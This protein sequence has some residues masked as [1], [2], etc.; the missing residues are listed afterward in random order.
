MS[1][2]AILFMFWMILVDEVAQQDLRIH[3]NASMEVLTE[4][5]ALNLTCETPPGETFRQQWLHPLQ[6]ASLY[7]SFLF[8]LLQC[9]Q[10]KL[11]SELKTYWYCIKWCKHI[12]CVSISNTA[13]YYSISIQARDAVFMKLVFPDKVLYILNI[14]KASVADSGLYQC[15]VTNQLTGQTKSVKLDVTVHG[16]C[17][18]ASAFT[19]LV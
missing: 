17:L 2:I 11:I 6:Q 16:M 12:P 18:T 4:G 15:A 3:L 5:D 9:K 10:H 14:P 7:S 13:F 1:L 8:C 19:L